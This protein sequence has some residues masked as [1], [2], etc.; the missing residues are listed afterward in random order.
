MDQG[1]TY[2]D[3]KMRDEGMPENQSTATLQTSTVRCPSPGTFN[4]VV[5][6]VNGESRKN[7]DF[8]IITRCSDVYDKISDTLG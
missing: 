4:D 1:G 3:Y 8:N 7:G 2:T 6:V 5:A